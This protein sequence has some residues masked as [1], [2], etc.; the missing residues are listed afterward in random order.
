MAEL[1]E[2]FEEVEDEELDSGFEEV[3]LDEGFDSVPMGGEF[4][5]VVSQELEAVPSAEESPSL[6]EVSQ[7]AAALEGAK[8]GVTM[9]FADEMGAGVQSS[10]DRM[11]R[12]LNEYT[13]LVDKSPTQVS[14]QMAEEGFTGDLGPTS[15][16]E[17]SEEALAENRL[18]TKAAEEQHPG[19]FL[20]ADVA[21]SFLLPVPGAAIAKVGAKVLPK[22]AQ[23]ASQL[24][25]VTKGATAGA[26]V[27]AV[28]AAGRTEED[29]LSLEGA[30]DVAFGASVG[31]LGGAVAGKIAKKL[32]SKEFTKKADELLE[33][34]DDQA[35]RALGAGKKELKEA[36]E[37]RFKYGD[38][39]NSGV[40][41]LEEGLVQPLAKPKQQY[42][43]V[44][45]KRKEIQK[46]YDRAIDKFDD[47][48][49]LSEPQ[50]ADLAAQ[51]FQ[52]IKNK[53]SETI[54][55]NDQITP[56]MKQ[57]L[58][59]DTADLQ[60]DILSALDSK[61]P[62]RDLQD[63]YVRYNDVFFKNVQGPTSQARKAIRNEIKAIQR[64]LADT[65]EQGTKKEFAE[66]DQK[67]TNI[68]DL[69]KITLDATTKSTKIG[70]GDFMAGATAKLS[71]IPGIGEVVTSAS[72]ASKKLLK[73]DLQ[74]VVDK[75]SALRKFKK[76]KKLQGLAVDPGVA[77]KA[78]RD[79][80]VMAGAT[81]AAV[82]SGFK[83][84]VSDRNAIE[85]YKMHQR[86]AKMAERA[87]PEM[88]MRQ[89]QSIREQ[90]GKLG[91]VLAST[92][93]RMADR[94]KAGRRALMFHLLQNPKNREMLISKEEDVLE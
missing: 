21:S 9:G 30:K 80:P 78:V 12:L 69:E 37:R 74:D 66:L 77:R 46:G 18:R 41:A 91:E 13:G 72:I 45:G 90:H 10:A 25:K 1:D 89:A 6:P 81:A 2:G 53:V 61:N 73:T 26:G 48:I 82:G 43:N 79:N 7:S 11:Q 23:Q 22:V 24:G 28:E 56:E 44:I 15:P 75:A 34:A 67:Y 68:L 93:E 92:L 70:F 33:D 64:E 35:L 29:L 63:L 38:P 65:V 60:D 20:A 54:K 5:D 31:G 83:D 71:G 32:E 17:L 94:D 88:L 47:R 19:T 85:P 36:T 50:A 16:E 57:R 14:E 4:S 62:I 40:M 58:G 84:S 42:Q 55:G 8:Q 27:G 86:T 59:Q 51:Y 87:T 52:R 76:A 3:A 49:N 39:K